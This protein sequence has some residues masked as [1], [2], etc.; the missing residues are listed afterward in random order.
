MSPVAVP[1][2]P[3]Q[4]SNLSRKQPL[5]D[6]AYQR[7]VAMLAERAD[8]LEMSVRGLAEQLDRP[9]TTVHKTLTGQRRMDPIEFV[10]WCEA[11]GFDDP[12]KLVKSAVRKKR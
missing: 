3:P 9:R 1:K 2:R 5:Q 4:Q 10:A 6:E 7:L 11:L 12:V 8:E